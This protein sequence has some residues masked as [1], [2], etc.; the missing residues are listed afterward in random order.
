[1]I[2]AALITWVLTAAGGF[3]LL[4]VWLKHGGMSEQ[5]GGR[6]CS[7][8]ILTHFALAAVGLVLW[9]VYVA[10]DSSALPWIAFVLLLVVALIG[11][12][13]SRSGSPSDHAARWRPPN[14]ASRWRSSGCTECLRLRHWCSC[15]S[16]PQARH[17]MRAG[18]DLGRGRTSEGLLEA[19]LTGRSTAPFCRSRCRVAHRERAAGRR[20][21]PRCEPAAAFS[22]HR[23]RT[24]AAHPTAAEREEQLLSASA[25]P[26]EYLRAIEPIGTNAGPHI[27]E[28]R[29]S[30]SWSRPGFENGEKHQ[31]Y[32]VRESVGIAV[33]FLVAALHLSV[34]RRSRMAVADGLSRELLDR[35]ENERPFLLLPVGDPAGD[36]RSDL[37]KKT[38]DDSPSGLARSDGRSGNEGTR[39]LT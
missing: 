20:A 2:W 34:S 5:D 3:V 14:S 8:R 37:Q 36:A 13:C 17:L 22:R 1:M 16:Q 18:D 30:R 19:M 32:Y 25:P 10:S 39:Y 26:R 23:R 24:R 15:A 9:I 33:G 6:I 35:P 28:R 31:H 38:L 4:V 27:T 12:R 7:A 11:F 29:R 21:A